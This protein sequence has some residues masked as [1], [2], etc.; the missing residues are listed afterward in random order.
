M[1]GAL[2]QAFGDLLEPKVRV[3]V[4]QVALLTALAFAAVGGLLWWAFSGFDPPDASLGLDLGLFTLPPGWIV[5]AL[6]WTVNGLL[7][8]FGVL[9]FL[10]LFWLGFVVVAQNVAGLF[11][12]KV[13]DAVEARHFPGLPSPGQSFRQAIAA[14][15]NLTAM[16]I[17]VN[18]LMLPVY[19]ILT[20]LPPANLV[21]FYLVNGYLFGREYFETVA[22][23]REQ[24]PAA[25]LLW[26]AR[27]G[28]WVLA[29]AIIAG[30][31]SVP[32]LNFVAPI[33]G[34]AFMTHLL[35]RARV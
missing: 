32:V 3:V 31:M 34:A 7:G 21:L 14:G 20:F 6:V 33:V 27:R 24:G 29:G 26:R 23:R 16:V 25:E 5:D 22:Y 19:L 11:L 15:F 35:H 4:V 2:V 13:V 1:I 12:D 18:L 8:I 30:L 10:A 17:G 28:R 9:L